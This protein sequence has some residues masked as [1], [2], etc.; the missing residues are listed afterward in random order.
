MNK[1]VA[2][3][4]IAALS[5]IGYCVGRQLVK[6]SEEKS[7]VY[8]NTKES[9][10]SKFHRASMFAVG[11]IKTGADKVAEGISDIMNKDMVKKGEDTIEQAKE[12]TETVKDNVKKEIENL[13]N[14]VVSI[15]VTPGEAQEEGFE[16]PEA[17][18]EIPEESEKPE[19]KAE[20]VTAPTEDKKPEV[21]ADDY[22]FT[23]RN[24]KNS[25]P[26]FTSDINTAFG[27]VSNIGFNA[28]AEPEEDIADFEEEDFSSSY[29]SL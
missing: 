6:K 10:D 22:D 25:V 8:V 20:E 3:L 21:S 13:K 17:D 7:G 26:D 2:F 16:E 4:G 27:S 15:N 5:G 23:V 28:T 24:E 19:E 1:L 12:T 29:E 18:Q 11:A 14:M 9:T